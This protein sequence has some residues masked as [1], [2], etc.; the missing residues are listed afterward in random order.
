M[1]EIII[2]LYAVIDLVMMLKSRPRVDTVTHEKSRDKGG[3]Q[4]REKY[5]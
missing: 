3:Q 2:Y 4:R 5:K 1:E